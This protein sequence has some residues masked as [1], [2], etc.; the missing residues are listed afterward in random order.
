MQFL[1]QAVPVKPLQLCKAL[2]VCKS[3]FTTVK[4]YISLR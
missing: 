2:S 1:A 4:L 3:I